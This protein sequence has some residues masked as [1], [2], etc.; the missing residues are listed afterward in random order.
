M[1]IR[2]HW[3]QSTWCDMGGRY[4]C[5][6]STMSRVWFSCRVFGRVSVERCQLLKSI[7]R[8]ISLYNCVWMILALKKKHWTRT[9]DVSPNICIINTK[10][11]INIAFK[12]K[13]KDCVNFILKCIFKQIN[14][15]FKVKLKVGS[16]PG[17]FVKRVVTWLSLIF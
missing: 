13:L 1:C 7:P 11:Q 14:L 2:T 9:F 17:Q 10:E 8:G 5:L 4:S 16:E 15:A 12:V 6:L 3:T